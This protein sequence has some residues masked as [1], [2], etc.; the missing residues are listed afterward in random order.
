[1]IPGTQNMKRILFPKDL[2]KNAEC[3]FDYA[4]VSSKSNTEAQA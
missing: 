2:S 4:A 1:M 3:A